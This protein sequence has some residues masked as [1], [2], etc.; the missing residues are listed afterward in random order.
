MGI[1]KKDYIYSGSSAQLAGDVWEDQP[2][3]T[4]TRRSAGSTTRC[5]CGTSGDCSP[6]A[7]QRQRCA[8]VAA[9]DSSRWLFGTSATREFVQ[10]DAKREKS[11]TS[12]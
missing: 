7:G 5:P 10:G 3:P 2:N 12:H 9:A 4:T 1:E 6:S 11:E 8:A